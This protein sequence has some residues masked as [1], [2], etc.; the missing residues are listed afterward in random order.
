MSTAPA[1][2]TSSTAVAP[3]TKVESTQEA[4]HG[5]SVSNIG[6]G[7]AGPEEAMLHTGAFNTIDMYMRMQFLALASFRWDTAQAPGTLLWS[8]PISPKNSHQFIRH[9]S[10]MYNT[11]VGGFD[12]NVKVCG[13]GFH[14]GA[15]AVVRLPPNI[16][17]SAVSAPSDFTAFEYL[18]IDPKTLEVV[19]EH[20][21]DQRRWMYHYM[22]DTGIDSI[23]GHL[24]VYVLVQLNTSSTGS[25][26]IAIQVLSRPS[27]SFN[28][29]QIKPLEASGPEP[30]PDEPT[31]IVKA[32]QVTPDC[33]NSTATFD[34]EIESIVLTPMTQV[35]PLGSLVGCYTFEGKQLG[36]E[37][38]GTYPLPTLAFSTGK[39]VVAK[40]G[41][42][43]C[44]QSDTYKDMPTSATMNVQ[45]V[46]STNGGATFSGETAT[47]MCESGSFQTFSTGGTA[48][49]KN[50]TAYVKIN[51]WQETERTV[52]AKPSDESYVVFDNSAQSQLRSFQTAQL[53]KLLAT[54]DWKDLFEKQQAMI[55]DLYDA[56][57][58]TPVRRFKLYYNGILT[59]KG[60]E[61]E[62]TL[63]AKKYYTKFVQYSRAG[64]PI[65]APQ[66]NY[67][68]NTVLS[69]LHQKTQEQTQITHGDDSST[70]WSEYN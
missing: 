30:E 22:N 69:L 29:F 11:W 38:G 43:T 35:A 31:T 55:I 47:K 23:G 1:V 48:G 5:Q 10:Q 7:G 66:Q 33:K 15:L 64:E 17:P 28:F 56:E 24:A 70:Y 42:P 16:S 41:G 26:S 6:H 2:P 37:K 21:I 46:S 57:L 53:A 14:A 39:L 51:M 8:T 45:V 50:A 61:N 52:P 68:L 44:F 3:T 58:D 27:Q 67:K 18:I 19:T 49:T 65:P 59:T 40:E 54:G 25:Q 9:L 13:T 32:I 36:T 20:I 12:Y 60:V 62:I 34:R 4:P 63:P